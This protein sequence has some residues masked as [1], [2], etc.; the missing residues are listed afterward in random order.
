VLEKRFPLAYDLAWE[1]YVAIWL[2][3]APVV[4]PLRYFEESCLV[5]TCVF[6]EGWLSARDSVDFIILLEEF[7]S[8]LAVD[9]CI[10]C[11]C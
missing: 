1:Y 6:F 10:C 2:E 8:F 4:L 3:L 11:T 9:L 5:N 7:K